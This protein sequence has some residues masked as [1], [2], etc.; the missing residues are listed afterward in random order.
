MVVTV[1]VSGLLLT[2]TTWT[3]VTGVGVHVDNGEL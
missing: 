2:V 1:C 3:D